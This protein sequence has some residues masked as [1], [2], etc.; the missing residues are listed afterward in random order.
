MVK[1]YTGE[2]LETYIYSKSAIDH[3]HRYA[4]ASKFVK[5]KIVLD[6]AS[7]EGYG[8]NLISK[9]AAFVYGVDIDK[10]TVANAQLKY[11]K[12]NLKFLVGNTSSISL[13]NNSVD[14]VISFETI[15]HHNEHDEMMFEIKRVLKPSGMLIISTPDKLTYSDKRNY[16]N[17][18]H[19]KELYKQEFKN[20]IASHFENYQLLN[21]SY[22]NGNSLVLDEINEREA[23][24]FTGNYSL[25][26]E[27]NVDSLY[28]IILASDALFDKQNMSV[29][30]GA[31][32]LKLNNVDM[33][34][35]KIYN[36]N[37]YKTGHFILLPFKI[38]KKFYKNIFI[39]SISG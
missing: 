17:E 11:K 21:Q 20:L 31:Q 37:S 38:L 8:S 32:I 35:K 34:S 30:D 16:N 33:I 25:L 6:I 12:E 2:R 19:V 1:K 5:D 13:E 15:E 23:V 10:T 29:F 24:F 22:I 7:G 14:I 9:D 36:S 27:I 26:K 18:F 3:L 28:L 4:I 39:N